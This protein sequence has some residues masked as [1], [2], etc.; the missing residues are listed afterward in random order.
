MKFFDTVISGELNP[1]LDVLDS[2]SSIES[3]DS[4]TAE[5]VAVVEAQAAVDCVD[6]DGVDDAVFL[7]FREEVEGGSASPEVPPSS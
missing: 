1:F 6:G 5:F 2:V 4:E 7:D 3:A